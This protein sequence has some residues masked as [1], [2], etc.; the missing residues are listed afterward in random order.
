M[1]ICWIDFD[2]FVSWNCIGGA[3]S[4]VGRSMVYVKGLAFT[5]A[6]EWWRCDTQCFFLFPL[7]FVPLS[8]GVGDTKNVPKFDYIVISLAY[9][10]YVLGA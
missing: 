5:M 7:V 4:L 10:A 6:G 8:T 9:R 3:A 2:G 1:L